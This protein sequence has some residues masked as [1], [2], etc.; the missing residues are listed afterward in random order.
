MDFLALNE[1]KVKDKH[2]EWFENALEVKSGVGEKT[3]A[4]E[5]VVLLLK[6]ELCESVKEF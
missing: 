2:E 1:T 6:W 3:R 4:K 5:G